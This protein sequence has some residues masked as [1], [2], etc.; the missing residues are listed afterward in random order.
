MVNEF[1]D[2]IWFY[3]TPFLTRLTQNWTKIITTKMKMTKNFT[4]EY[5][6]DTINDY[7]YM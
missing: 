7:V 6:K 1:D 2:L 5:T 3:R 4:K